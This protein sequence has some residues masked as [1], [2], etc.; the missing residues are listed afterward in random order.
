MGFSE[1][2]AGPALVC[3]AHPSA[4]D[5]VWDLLWLPTHV[6]FSLRLISIIMRVYTKSSEE[7]GGQAESYG[8]R[9]WWWELLQTLTIFRRSQETGTPAVRLSNP[10]P[11]AKQ[12]CREHPAPALAPLATQSC[13]GRE[14]WQ[15][16]SPQGAPSS[17]GRKK[18]S[19]E[20]Q[21][22]IT[23]GNG[24]PTMEKRWGPR[25]VSLQEQGLEKGALEGLP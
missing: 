25:G 22:R 6:Y 21:R 12:P 11:W 20:G 1:E 5:A 3:H 9:R 18:D 8:P 14:G 24:L 4:G 10:T 16:G 23:K 17:N 7:G 15:S 19:L 2:E 13:P